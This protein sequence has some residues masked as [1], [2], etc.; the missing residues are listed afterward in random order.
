MD[1]NR[2]VGAEYIQTKRSTS[3]IEKGVIL[4]LDMDKDLLVGQG[5]DGKKHFFSLVSFKE[6]GNLSFSDSSIMKELNVY[7]EEKEQELQKQI[8]EDRKRKE[9]ELIDKK[10]I[11]EAQKA[12]LR[13]S[14]AKAKRKK[15]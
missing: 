10:V 11:E 12:A 15:K 5:E 7:F 4:T 3:S 1:F 9:Q 2:L 6:G 14:K 8:I 13:K